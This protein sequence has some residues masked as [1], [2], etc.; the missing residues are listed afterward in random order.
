MS[1]WTSSAL[2]CVLALQAA[3]GAP[4]AS[5]AP[6]PTAQEQRLLQQYREAQT[7]VEQYRGSGNIEDLRL[8]RGKLTQWLSDH[9]I[10]YGTQTSAETVRAPI[11]QQIQEIDAILATAS[12]PPPTPPPSPEHR[13]A[14]RFITAGAVLI[15]VGVILGATVSL[16]LFVLRESALDRANRQLFYV[17]EQHFV[18]RARRFQAGGWVTMGLSLAMVGAGVALLATGLAQRSHRRNVAFAPVFGE[19]FTGGVAHFHF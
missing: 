4:P 2:V 17:D 6:L 13:S 16:P 9:E 8:A 15:P 7:L 1:V 10:V 12:S 3:N 14:R 11:R 19:H 18:D 5:P